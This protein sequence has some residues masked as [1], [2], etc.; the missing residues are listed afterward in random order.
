MRKILAIMLAAVLLCL[1]ASCGEETASYATDIA[2]ADLAAAADAALAAETPLS[3]VP[4]DYIIGMME[5]DVS[6]FE[7]HIVKIQA[8]GASIDEYGIFK[9]PTSE[10]V[11]SIK[12]IASEYIAARIDDWNPQYMPEEFPKM[13]SATIQTFGQY[14]VYC[15][16]D[17]NTK[18]AVFTAIENKLLGK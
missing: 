16:L 6:V 14:V 12:S 13:E 7:D 2:V 5:I 18:D 4:D 11:E 10:A 15:I 9:A 17:D 1:L 8:S 3:A